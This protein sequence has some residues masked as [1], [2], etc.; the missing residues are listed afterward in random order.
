MLPI[1]RQNGPLSNDR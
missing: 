1:G